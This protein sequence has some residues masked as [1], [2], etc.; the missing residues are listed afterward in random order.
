MISNRHKQNG[1]VLIYNQMSTN[2]N[3]EI[4][5]LSLIIRF[6]PHSQSRFRSLC[7][8]FESVKIKQY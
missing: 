1:K 4:F 7:Y 3:N 2:E 8:G 5:T 6:L